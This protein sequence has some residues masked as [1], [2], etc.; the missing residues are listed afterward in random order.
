MQPTS[1]FVGD[2][3]LILLNIRI[4]DAERQRDAD[5]LSSLL[6]DALQFRRANGSIVDKSTYLKDLKD[7]GNT[8]EYLVSEDVAAQIYEGAALV[9]L[10]VRAK[11]TRGSKPFEGIFRNIRI[12]LREPDK[13]PEWQLH[14]WFNVRIDNP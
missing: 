3:T 4:G 6:S 8:Y 1:P 11:G 10:R 7:P 12:F 14:S 5:F 9:T 2:Q 13:K